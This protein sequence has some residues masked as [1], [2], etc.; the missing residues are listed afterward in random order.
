[1]TVDL[2]SGS[3]LAFDDIP[4]LKDDEAPKFTLRTAVDSDIENLIRW[5]AAQGE[6][7]LLWLPYTAEMWRFELNHRHPKS[8]LVRTTYIITDANDR[9]VG[10]VVLMVSPYMPQVLCPA[11]VVDDTTSHLETCVD[12]FR[13]IRQI[14]ETFY[15]ENTPDM[16]KTV[17]FD[18]GVDETV[19]RIVDTFTLSKVRPTTYAWYLRVPNLPGFLKTIAP[20]LERRLKG[21]GA[22]NYTGDFSIHLYDTTALILKFET[23][24]LV[25]VTRERMLPE[26]NANLGFPYHSFLSILFGHR[27]LEELRLAYPEIGVNRTGRVLLDA[28]FPK[29]RSWIMAY[30]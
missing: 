10:Y 5:T 19:H 26:W 7:Y 9:A 27:S 30:A 1:M 29:K 8:S 11:Y 22:N 17:R 12:V 16:P 13:G 25:D 3:Q 23:G 18:S 14:A 20:V 24:K 15:A 28:L 2:G 4:E 21:S 6:K